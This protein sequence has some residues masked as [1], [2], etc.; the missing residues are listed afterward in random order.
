M[1]EPLRLQSKPMPIRK[2]INSY[3]F[4]LQFLGGKRG[5]EKSWFC[6]ILFCCSFF[7]REQR[8]F[9][10]LQQRERE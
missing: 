2:G 6:F 3:I 7:F 10:Q 9:H 4:S 1:L 5:T 8:I